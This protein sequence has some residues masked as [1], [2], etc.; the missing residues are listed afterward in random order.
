MSILNSTPESSNDLHFRA[1]HH[2]YSLSFTNTHP[3]Y[4][5]ILRCSGFNN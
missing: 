2:C 1:N 5:F 3:S 4:Y